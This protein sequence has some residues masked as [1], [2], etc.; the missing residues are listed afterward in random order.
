MTSKAFPGRT[1]IWNALFVPSKCIIVASAVARTGITISYVM[2]A[3]SQ[4]QEWWLHQPDGEAQLQARLH[5]VP[6][7]S[8]RPVRQETRHCHQEQLNRFRFRHRPL[9]YLAS[10]E[11]QWEQTI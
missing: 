7:A 10:L 1:M 11:K 6:S 5:Q 4:A 8:W 3:V 2:G 9:D